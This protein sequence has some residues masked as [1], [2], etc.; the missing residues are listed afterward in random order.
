MLLGNLEP[1]FPSPVFGQGHIKYDAFIFFFYDESIM[2]YN[3]C[4]LQFIWDLFYQLF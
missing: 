2:L 4:V 3:C 1:P